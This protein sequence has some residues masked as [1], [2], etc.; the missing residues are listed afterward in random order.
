[1]KRYNTLF[2]TSVGVFVFILI[3]SFTTKIVKGG[4]VSLME[5]HMIINGSSSEVIPNPQTGVLNLYCNNELI[6]PIS[7][8]LI[9]TTGNTV[10]CNII[11]KAEGIKDHKFIQLITTDF[12]TGEYQLKLKD[13]RGIESCRQIFI[14]K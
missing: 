10:Q 1:M 2:T 14:K 13:A 5:K 12:P 6:S 11:L 4:S 7:V 8:C 3:C 9:N